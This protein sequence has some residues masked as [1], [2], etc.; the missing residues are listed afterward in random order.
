[1]A[2]LACSEEMFSGSAK[3]LRVLETAWQRDDD[4][5]DPGANAEWEWAKEGQG[6]I[7]FRSLIQS[8]KREDKPVANTLAKPVT[9]PNTSDVHGFLGSK[10]D[11]NE[12]F[13]NTT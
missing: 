9:P 12:T 1:M 7:R 13:A 11:R 10:L 6:S 5:G 2:T 8:V 3:E 4:T